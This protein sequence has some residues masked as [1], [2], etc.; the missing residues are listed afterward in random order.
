M[1]EWKSCITKLDFVTQ[2]V[3]NMIPYYLISMVTLFGMSLLGYAQFGR[4]WHYFTIAALM[5][6]ETHTITRPVFPP[7]LTKILNPLIQYT[8]HPQFLPFQAIAI[9]RRVAL[10]VFIAV[11]QIAPRLRD[12]QTADEKDEAQ[13]VL[14]RINHAISTLDNTSLNLLNLQ[15]VPFMN[16]EELEGRLKEQMKAWMV[17]NEIRNDKGVDAAVRAALERKM[18]GEAESMEESIDALGS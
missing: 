3:K 6:F 16:D 9:A 14:A 7:I 17:R 18:R 13:Q 10:S 1:L 8:S 5:L 2:G 15:T 11:S 4:Y 12:Q